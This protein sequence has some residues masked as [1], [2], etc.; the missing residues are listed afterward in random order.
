M[1]LEKAIESGRGETEGARYG[2]D[3]AQVI[4]HTSLSI[5]QSKK[6]LD[7]GFKLQELP[8]CWSHQ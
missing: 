5:C 2:G 8:E 4:D 1:V 6:T 3:A 7:S